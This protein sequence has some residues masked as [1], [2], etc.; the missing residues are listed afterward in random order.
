MTENTITLQI[1]KRGSRWV[2]FYDGKQRTTIPSV[3]KNVCYGTPF[4]ENIDRMCVHWEGK[5]SDR[6]DYLDKFHQNYKPFVEYEAGAL[7]QGPCGTAKITSVDD[8]GVA[9]EVTTRGH[10]LSRDQFERSY[11]TLVT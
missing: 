2:M 6:F 11:P 8:I 10:T 9:Y 7:Y 4:G 3:V 5:G 1:P